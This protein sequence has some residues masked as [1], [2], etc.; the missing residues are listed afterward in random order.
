M[1]AYDPGQALIS[2]HVPKTA[3]TSLRL[4]LRSWFGE[5]LFF[6]YRGLEGEPPEHHTPSAGICIHGHFNRVRGIGA[7]DYYPKARQFIVFLRHPFS[8]TVSQWKYLHYQM[9]EGGRVPELEDHPTFE[10]WLARRRDLAMGQTEDPFATMAQLPWKTA[11]GAAFDDGYVFVGV[12]ERYEEDSR[13]LAKA[14][15]FPPA[16]VVHINRADDEVRRGDPGADL[17]AFRSFH[18]ASFPAEYEIYEAAHAWRSK[19]AP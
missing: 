13:A 19:H 8:R 10:T 17:S 14:L 12:L 2:L 7:L 9:R 3:G 5:R 16:T 15:G 6:H 1:A 4:A 18:A 11:P